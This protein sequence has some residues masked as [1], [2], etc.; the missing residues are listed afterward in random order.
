MKPSYTYSAT[1]LRWID[2][3]SCEVMFQLGFSIAVKQSIR[4]WGIDTSELRGGTPELK[5]LGMLAKQYVEEMAPVGTEV[6]IV[7][8]KKGKFGRYL[9]EIYQGSDA[10]L[11]L[12]E[13]L[14]LQ[15]LAVDYFGQ[16]KSEVLSAHQQNAEF[17]AQQRDSESKE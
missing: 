6:T 11:S 7:T 10:S 3:D 8:H 2:G 5:Y 15:R 4:L 14:K 17:H 16:S 12:N 13:A 9:G 1:I